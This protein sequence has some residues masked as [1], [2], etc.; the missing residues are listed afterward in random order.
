MGPGHPLRPTADADHAAV[1]GLTPVTD[2]ED[3]AA[4]AAD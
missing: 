3:A 1:H 4:P 2:A